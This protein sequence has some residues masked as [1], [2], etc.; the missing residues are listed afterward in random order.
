VA[1][2]P[3]LYAEKMV[4]LAQDTSRR[5]AYSKASKTIAQTLSIEAQTDKL[6]KVYEDAI[7]A[8]RLAVPKHSKEPDIL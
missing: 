5:K 8:K 7:V 2:D 1:H 6:L 4:A 3:P